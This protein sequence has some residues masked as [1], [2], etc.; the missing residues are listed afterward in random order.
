MSDSQQWRKP[1]VQFEESQ[2][3]QELPRSAVAGGRA[4]QFAGTR[5]S[6]LKKNASHNKSAPSIKAGASDSQEPRQRRISLPDSTTAPKAQQ[7][8]T[9][10]LTYDQVT[11]QLIVYSFYA[12]IVLLDIACNSPSCR[13]IIEDGCLDGNCCGCC[14]LQ[15]RSRQL[16]IAQRCHHALLLLQ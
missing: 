10:P 7:Q 11:F 6:L 14:N 4:Q 2:Q 16:S 3:S 9:Q 13:A 1:K 15:Q 8:A 12:T 5:K